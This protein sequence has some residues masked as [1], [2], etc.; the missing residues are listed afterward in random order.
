[1]R[2]TLTAG[3]AV[4]AAVAMQAA[5]A[6]AKDANHDH[7]PDGWERAYHLS[8]HVNQANKDQDH[9][10]L[11]NR[12]EFHDGTSPRDADS[13]NDGVKDLADHHDGDAQPPAPVEPGSDPQPNPEPERQDPAPQPQDPAPEHQDPQE[14]E[15]QE[16]QP[17]TPEPQPGVAHIVSYTQSPGFGGFLVIERA[18][19]EQ[20]TSY[21]GE[22]TDLECSDAPCTKDHL[23]A[24]AVVVSAEHGINPY[25]HDVWTKVVLG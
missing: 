5:P 23:V 1:M 13:D 7:L 12:G 21:F 10:G 11:R 25:G 6:L 24:G 17:P 18:N 4:I 16:P 3:A 9:D 14:P 19:G 20:V 2:R 15:H 8:L 22:K